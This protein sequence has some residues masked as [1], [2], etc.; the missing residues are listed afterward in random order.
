MISGPM[1]E[2]LE[3]GRGRYN[4]RFSA[5]RKGGAPVD[6]DS[7]LV[8]LGNAVGPVVESVAAEAPERVDG[9]L[10]SLFSVSLELFAAS[11]LGPKS[12]S[13]VVGEVWARLL[14][15]LPALVS[16]DAKTVA[17]GLSNAA[18]N[19]GR[20]RGAR[21]AEW[22]SEMRRVACTCVTVAE[23]LEVGKV[24]AWR[25]GMPQYRSSALAVTRG[26][27]P[28]LAAELLGVPPGSIS[29]T[30]DRMAADPW[31]TPEAASRDVP[32]ALRLI[33]HVG[34]FRGFG[35]EFLLPPNVFASSGCLFITDGEGTWRL[36]CDCYGCFLLRHDTAPK[37]DRLSD[38]VA[39]AADG[40]VRWGV[41]RASLPLL[42]GPSSTACD[43]HTLAVTLPTSHHVFVIA[44]A[45]AAA[46]VHD[47]R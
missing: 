10:E 37:P 3:R 34:G 46:E 45:P 35:G 16:R 31:L 2:A 1:A 9:V 33:R 11:L 7:F 6:G 21:P 24:A 38:D 27:R 28:E 47:G 20:T 23:L 18:Y 32:A 44:R 17:A 41:G 4:A 5:A 15:A 26:M 12:K 22:L 43:G 40:T 29:T 8:H 30:L 36:I 39:I 42:A 14:P 13:P 19:L 25:A